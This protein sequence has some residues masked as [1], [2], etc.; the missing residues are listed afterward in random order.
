M[1]RSGN[2]L[3]VHRARAGQSTVEFVRSRSSR[4][5]AKPKNL[6]DMLLAR[7][8]HVIPRCQRPYVW[9]PEE[10]GD[11]LVASVPAIATAAIDT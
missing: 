2:E 6:E 8:Q 5:D 9:T 11:S 10:H 7:R 1:S 4:V 3:R